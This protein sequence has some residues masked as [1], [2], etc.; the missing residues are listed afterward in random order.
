MVDRHSVTN[1]RSFVIKN[2]RTEHL[3]QSFFVKTVAE[4]NHLGT[5]T[6]RSETVESFKE[7]LTQCY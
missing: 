5:G 6:V 2:C 4:W 3:K 7:S 1:D